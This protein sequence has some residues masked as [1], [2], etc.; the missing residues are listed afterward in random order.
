MKLKA[1][2]GIMLILFVVSIAFNVV[3]VF[4]S[5][6]YIKIGVVGP[7]GWIQWDGLWEGAM[8][9]RDE[10]NDAG[11]INIGESFY[12]I[13]LV[14]IDEH[15]VPLPDP[16]A[17]ITELLVSLT[18][19][20]DMQF[21]IGGFKT[22]CVFPMREA[23]M[24]YA[25]VHGRPIWFVCGVAT[26]ELID[27]G[28]GTCGHCVRCDYDRYKYMFRVSPVNATTLLNTLVAFLTDYV[29]PQKLAP[30][31]GSPVK[32]YIVAEDLVWCDG[33]VASLQGGALGT[34]A[35]I[36]GVARPSPVA[37]DFSPEFSDAEAK[38]ARLV[39]HIFSAVAGANFIRQYGLLKPNFAC[40]GIN[41]ESQMQE[42]YSA[43]GGA[44]EHETILAP[45]G[46]R[47]NINPN[48]KP[49]STIQF[50]DEY[51]AR[52][53]HCP[54]YTAWG[55]YDAIMAL[56]ETL[57]G[58]PTLPNCTTLIPIIEQTDRTGIIGKFKYTGPNGIY[59]DVFCNE[60]GPTWTQGYVRPL[61]VQ[62][63][64][65]RMEVVWPRDQPYS[66]DYEIPPW[67]LLPPPSY[68]LTIYSSPTG[69]TFTVDGVSRT[70]PW[71]GT[72]SEGTLVSLVMSETHDGY[73]WS[74]WFE[75]GDTNRIRTVTM[76]TNIT[77][78]AVF[79]DQER[80]LLLET[81]KGVYERGENVTI[82]FTNGGVETVYFLA[83][84]PFIINGSQGYVAPGV[85][86]LMIV[87]VPPRESLSWTWNQI[88]GFLGPSELVPAGNYTVTAEV[89]DSNWDLI[90]TLSTSFQIVE[91]EIEEPRPDDDTNSTIDL[92]SLL[93]ETDKAVYAHGEW[94]NITFT[95]GGNA[96]VEL[97]SWPCFEIYGS[98]GYVAPTVLAFMIVK[99]PPRGSHVWTWDQT[100]FVNGLN[101]PDLVDLV[102]PGTYAVILLIRDPA[103]GLWVGNLTTSFEIEPPTV[104]EF[105]STIILPLFMILSIIAVIFTK[106]RLPRKPVN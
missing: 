74:Y 24:D 63:Q 58:K 57:Y 106:R 72:Y 50:W 20:P 66:F 31:Y 51:K 82:T 61:V 89:Y 85:Q 101:N 100:G 9:A 73:V 94:V 28:D 105:P 1:V 104:P 8:M 19:N 81:D 67:M 30:I 95:N 37:I 14:D 87:E 5:T 80:Q 38:E 32:T 34:Q 55:A 75:D 22:E 36:V 65:G 15:A 62:W 92:G 88:N 43:V 11:G 83:Y 45:V 3:P 47:T 7:K 42:F 97:T 40:I 71:S 13:Q 76:D 77:L 52:Y 41:V 84:P 10:I 29:L 98:Q 68:T 103:T 44:C 12:N 53:G 35:E 21:L 2:S 33:I 79:A 18:D 69:A 48:A 27:C 16:K 39:V 23:A 54:I 96:T 60:L 99:V 70:T 46:T 64:A 93:L 78:T 86:L 56:N 59:H 6:Q 49:L 91:P 4:G 26:D 90:A 25:E 102:P 17:A